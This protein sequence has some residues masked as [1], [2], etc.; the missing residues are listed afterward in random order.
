MAGWPEYCPDSPLQPYWGRRDELSLQD[1]CVLWGRR[2]IIPESL[3]ERLLGELHELH[4][5][6][7]RMKALARSFVWWPAIDVDIEEKV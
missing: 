1:G 7:C 5:G 2:V 3:Q 4:P 6:M